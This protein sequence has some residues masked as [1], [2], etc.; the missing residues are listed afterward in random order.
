MD[1]LA[2]QVLVVHDE[3]DLARQYGIGLHGPCRG[4]HD[5]CL[6]R[7]GHLLQRAPGLRGQIDDPPQTLA[8]VVVPDEVVHQF[9][10]LGDNVVQRPAQFRG[11]RPAD[12]RPGRVPFRDQQVQY[13]QRQRHVISENLRKLAVFL[14]EG[15]QA[16]RLHVQHA[17][18]VV[19]HPQRDGQATAGIGQ[20]GQVTSILADIRADVALPRGGDISTNPVAFGAC[21]ELV[22]LG[23]RAQP[24]GDEHVQVV[25][26]LVQK[27]DREV[28][29]VQNVAAAVDEPLG[30]HPQPLTGV[31]AAV[32][33]PVDTDQFPSR[34]IDG[35][36]FQL[37]AALARRVDHD[38]RHLPQQPLPIA[39]GGCDQF[40]I[41]PPLQH[42]A[43]SPPMLLSLPRG[44]GED[45]VGLPA[46]LPDPRANRL[47]Q[48]IQLAIC[49]DNLAS[50]ADDAHA[51]T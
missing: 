22:L 20:P 10:R 7:L 39:D 29:V 16:V 25:G 11:D 12:L 41:A 9:G 40:V 31:E 32:G 13:V 37:L 30:E 47:R 43:E 14:A 3:H 18:D 50:G 44:G 15:L 26:P 34:P 24:F 45:L 38:G 51:V 5:S 17:D 36:E 19:M 27:H 49:P 1:R 35:V 21:E 28:L 8:E 4:C 42:E 46:Q 2:D 6:G 23:F 33:V 48:P